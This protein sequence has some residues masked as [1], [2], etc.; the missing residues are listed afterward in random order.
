M[1]D[2]PISIQ[3]ASGTL[4]VSRTQIYRL[5]QQNILNE[6]IVGDKRMVSSLSVKKYNLI[7]CQ[8]NELKEKM[9]RKDEK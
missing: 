2:I 1:D 5:L 9:K 4:G 3:L 6:I 7:R 8:M